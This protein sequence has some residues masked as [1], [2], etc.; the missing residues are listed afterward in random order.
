MKDKRPESRHLPI[1]DPELFES[2]D[3]LARE[4]AYVRTLA[5]KGADKVTNGN[6]AE[7]YLRDLCEGLLPWVACGIAETPAERR[8]EYLQTFWASIRTLIVA[9]FSVRIE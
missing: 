7:S 9:Q 5:E 3:Q 8:K 1:R 6:E 2:L 4:A